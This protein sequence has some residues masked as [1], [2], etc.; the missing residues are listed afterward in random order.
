MK[1]VGKT[2]ETE[3]NLK[4]EKKTMLEKLKKKK[5]NIL[6]RTYFSQT[7]TEKDKLNWCFLKKA[8]KRTVDCKTK[9]K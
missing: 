2:E 7:L 6:Y 4:T 5:W 8:E 1:N 9:L 3:I